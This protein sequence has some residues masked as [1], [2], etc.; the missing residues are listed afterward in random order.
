VAWT[1]FAFGGIYRT[2]LAAPAVAALLLI[3]IYRPD[4]L[5]R[6]PT[7]VLDRYLLS[8]AGAAAFQLLP[9]PSFLLGLLSPATEP[10]VR[11]LSLAPPGAMS[12]ITI[13]PRDSMWALLQFCGVLA[14][15]FC[16]RQIFTAGGVRTVMRGLALTGLVLAGIAIAQ[17]ATARGLMYW[18]W[19]TI[20]E[21]P[22][23]FGPFVN[24][25]HFA[26][27][28]IVTTPLC[29][30]YLMA[31]ATAHRGPRAGAPAMR[32]LRAALD[33]RGGLLL[34]A[35]VALI[36]ATALS[37]SRSGM[38]G[39]ATAGVCAAVL[40]RRRFAEDPAVVARPALL[41]A[42]AGVLSIL[43]ILWRIDPAVLTG[44]LTTS[45]VGAA[46]R[47]IIWR[48]T[49]AVVRDFWLTGTGVGTYQ[50][51][52]AV[53]QRGMPGV[54]FNQAHNH[55]LQIVSEG[56]LLVGIPAA[57]ALLALVRNTLSRL[58]ADRTGI[59][60]V[61]AGAASGLCGVAI[62]SVLETGLTTPANAA[63]AAV[64]AAV[65]VHSPSRSGRGH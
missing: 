38:A 43:V 37:L 62:Q 32:R 60:W 31:H 28:A 21:G 2:H 18:T 35:A 55:Y 5:Q 54:I 49:M 52:M 23:P 40:I 39:L 63:I 36:F 26:T 58:M 4:I 53:Y 25:N 6:G 24:R 27:W 33:A 59:F 8:I 1:T 3:V 41:V 42:G 16:A 47:L 45:A 57:L 19:R 10:V 56:G 30:G 65:V 51:S 14:V 15:F 29:L 17:N 46:D 50:L 11:A 9:L 61:R 7:P 12:P 13:G 48:D 34:I 20:D 64:A 44:R 22:D